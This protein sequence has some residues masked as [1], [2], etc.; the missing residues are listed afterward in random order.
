VYTFT[1][2]PG[3]AESLGI[4]PQN[5]A[6]AQSFTATDPEFDFSVPITLTGA[7]FK[8]TGPNGDVPL[9]SVDLV[10]N[11]QVV[12]L[13][14]AAPLAPETTY[15]ASYTG[16]KTGPELGPARAGQPIA[17]DK[18]QFTT[19]TFRLAR[20]APTDGSGTNLD[21][22]TTVDPVTVLKA[23]TLT[24]VFNNGAAV[25]GADNNSITISEQ[26]GTA[27]AKIPSTLTPSSSGKPDRFQLVLP[28]YQPKYGQKYEVRAATTITDT[29]SHKSVKA[30][31]CTGAGAACDD[32]K[33]FTTRKVTISIAADPTAAAPTGF[34]VNFSDPIAASSL[35]PFL[36]TRTTPGAYKLFARDSTGALSTTPTPIDCAISGPKQVKC[37]AAAPLGNSPNSFVASAVF[38]PTATTDPAAGGPS[39]PAIVDPATSTDPSAR[40]SGS[41]NRTI[42]AACGP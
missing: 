8:L 10:A 22:A 4:T 24:T 20:V 42:F 28:G 15:T 18:A 11:N 14:P 40:F 35:T 12:L 2:A 33:T 36:T 37:T 9:S 17:D 7:T 29:V 32:V 13:T 1:G 34:V 16:V 30:E 19:A 21:R 23:G 27:T 3:N 6:Q 31:G 5:G 41:A 25:A 39:G 26:N 38:L